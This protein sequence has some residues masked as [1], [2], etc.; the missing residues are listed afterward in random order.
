[1]L[2]PV[3]VSTA[4]VQDAHEAV[5]FLHRQ[6]KSFTTPA[7][8]TSRY[9]IASTVIIEPKIIF[10]RFQPSPPINIPR[11]TNPQFIAPT[12][13]KTVAILETRHP[14]Q[15]QLQFDIFF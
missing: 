1:M 12:T 3:G 15:L 7:I 2:P 8:P 4:Q 13:T 10:T 5:H 14:P 6:P 11:P 9:T